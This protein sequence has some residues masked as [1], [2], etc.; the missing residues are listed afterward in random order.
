MK[1]YNNDIFQDIFGLGSHCIS[2]VAAKIIKKSNALTGAGLFS[3]LEY[4]RFSTLYNDLWH[5]LSTPP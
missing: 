5:N 1:N 3:F 2:P 4:P